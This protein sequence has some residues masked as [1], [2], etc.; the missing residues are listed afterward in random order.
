M[1]DQ[2]PQALRHT[3]AAPAERPRCN[4][5]KGDP[6][7]ALSASVQARRPPT[8]PVA[9]PPAALVGKRET[10][11]RTC[12]ARSCGFGDSGGFRA[13]RPG[14]EPLAPSEHEERGRGRARAPSARWL[15][16]SLA[17]RPADLRPRPHGY[18]T[19]KARCPPVLPLPVAGGAEVRPESQSRPGPDSARPRPAGARAPSRAPAD[20]GPSPPQTAPHARRVTRPRRHLAAAM[21]RRPRLTVF[22]K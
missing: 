2:S 11:S 12:Q 13:A 5:R 22:V 20:T 3:Q 4:C 16:G 10:L 15:A 14:R 19:A 18:A 9:P 7:P 17:E 1:S 21:A 8:L 6:G